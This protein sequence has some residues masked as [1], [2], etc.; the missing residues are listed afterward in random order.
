MINLDITTKTTGKDNNDI[1]SFINIGDEYHKLI[2]EHLSEIAD[3]VKKGIEDNLKTGTDI[4]GNAVAPKKSG[5]G[6][7]FVDTGELLNSVLS[8]KT[9]VDS[10]QVYINSNRSTI[11]YYLNE[12]TDKMVARQAFGLS[13]KTNEKIDEYIKQLTSK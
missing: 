6:K 1:T 4:F 9:G 8:Q 5:K 13:N 12:G 10:Y 3:I 2:L 11:M 7:I